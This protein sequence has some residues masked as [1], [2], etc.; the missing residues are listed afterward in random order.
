M[1]GPFPARTSPWDTRLHGE[2][3]SIRA[4]DRWRAPRAFDALGPTGT[5]ADRPATSPREMVS[6]ASNDY[7]GLSSHPALARAA[8]DAVDRW[9]T[10][11][12]ASRLVVGTRPVHAELEEALASW[13]ATE[14]AVVFS[15]GYAANLG[16]I[17]ALAG[18]GVLICSD[19]HNH[20]SII[21]GCRLARAN[22]AQLEVFRHGD[23]DHLERLLADTD[24]PVAM[25]VS[26]TVFS[27][28]GNVAPIADLVACCERHG[29]LVLLD[30]AHDVFGHGEVR[31]AD[32]PVVRVGT[33]SKM[34]GSL[35]GFVA[36]PGPITELVVNRARSYIFTTALS[37]ADAA[38][39]LA[40]V[41]LLETPD[42]DELRARLRRVIDRFRPGHPTPIVPVVVGDEA[43]AVELSRRLEGDGFLVPAIRPPTVPPGTSRLRVALCADHDLTDAGRLAATIAD[44]LES[45]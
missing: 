26:D 14:A 13:K 20:A 44:H 35:G 4:A 15:S 6:F 1:S 24:A 43:T 27:M 28:D 21:D 3:E 40:A 39:A 33:L 19:E 36:G 23:V 45:P 10:G 17:S 32:V 18:R 29:A 37:P 8:H 31:G 34:L 41:T 30:D 11:A 22:G 9:G 25:V 16:T 5:M 7:L 38:A 42:G 2:L 12:T